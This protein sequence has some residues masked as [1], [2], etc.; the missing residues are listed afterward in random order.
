[1]R[2]LIYL[3]KFATPY[4][5]RLSR[6]W[7]W[8]LMT[9]NTKAFLILTKPNLYLSKSQCFQLVRRKYWFVGNHIP[10]DQLPRKLLQY[11]LKSHIWPNAA[12]V[13]HP[14]MRN[15]KEWE[16]SEMDIGDGHIP[17]FW[18]GEKYVILEPRYV[19]RVGAGR[20]LNSALY[21]HKM[22]EASLHLCCLHSSSSCFKWQGAWE[23]LKTLNRGTC[24]KYSMIF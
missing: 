4:M 2:H 9:S 19:G 15:I 13:F 8:I 18:S 11:Q 6:F 20:W 3:Y 7:R 14:P 22:F 10:R 21:C 12:L 5:Q 24:R 17:S 16:K 23:C 1:M